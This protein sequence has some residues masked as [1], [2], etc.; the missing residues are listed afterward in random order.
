MD[1]LH[2]ML[3]LIVVGVLLWLVNQYVPMQ[4]TI[5]K[6]L[7]AVVIICVVLWLLNIFGL[8][9]GFGSLGSHYRR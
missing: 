1:L 6:I 2:I 3:V 7:N 5:K 9:S 4:G 8:L